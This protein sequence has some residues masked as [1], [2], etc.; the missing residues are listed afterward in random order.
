MTPLGSL[1]KPIRV[2]FFGPSY[3]SIRDVTGGIR[4]N[5]RVSERGGGANLSKSAESIRGVRV[6]TLGKSHIGH[7]RGG[8]PGL[9]VRSH[10]EDIMCL[11]GENVIP[12]EPR[13]G[14][15]I[16]RICK[17]GNNTSWIPFELNVGKELSG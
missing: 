4:A 2:S 11:R 17:E 13:E 12:R 9:V 16:S 7:A 1:R 10:D 5:P 6:G 3:R 15:Y 14:Q 8:D